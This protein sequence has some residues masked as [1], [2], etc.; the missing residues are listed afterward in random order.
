MF[1]FR[2]YLISDHAHARHS[3]LQALPALAAAGL[4]ALQ[5]REK[6]RSPLGQADYALQ[7]L[8]A[9]GDR[10]D[11]LW[12]F[13][14]D[15]AD[16]ALSL[17]LDGVHLRSDSLP[18]ERHAPA[19]RDG[20]LYGVSTHSLAG[21]RAAEAAGADFI[22]FGPVYDTPSKAPYGPPVGLRPLEQVARAVRVPVFALG[23]IT[24]ARVRECLDA[25]AH[26][27]S[28][29]SAVWNA[30]HPVEALLAFRDALGSL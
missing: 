1:L 5:V 12:L 2:F 8:H 23:G 14:N 25:G 27:V 3:P 28:A 11:G 16:I 22:T 20:L 26:G 7:L 10:R 6:E 15:R 30:P 19:L 13:L 18:L 24:P 4:R 17:G 9:L 29:I 21:A